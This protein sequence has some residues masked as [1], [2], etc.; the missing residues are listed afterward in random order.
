VTKKLTHQ[1]RLARLARLHAQW[2][3]D[4]EDTPMPRGN[5][6]DKGLHHIDL[7][8]PEQAEAK[9]MAAATRIFPRTD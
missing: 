8:S 4:N 9:F 6:K 5:R 3:I 1:E 2:S 7:A